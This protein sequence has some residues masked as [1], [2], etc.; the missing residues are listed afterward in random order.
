MGK[1]IGESFADDMFVNYISLTIFCSA[2]ALLGLFSQLNLKKSVLAIKKLCPLAFGIYLVH[3]NQLVFRRILDKAFVFATE[4]ST[5][6]M[7]GIIFAAFL[8]FLI[9]I[10]INF[11]RYNL[12]EVLNI[13]Y[14]TKKLVH[15]VEKMLDR[16]Y[17]RFI[18]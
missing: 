2:V 15:F 16:M 10:F 4:Y 1:L 6:E 11:L 18:L 17:H 14:L 9:S 8:I 7:L 12:F 13:R 5:F 3:T